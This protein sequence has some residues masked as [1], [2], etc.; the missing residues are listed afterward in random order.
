MINLELFTTK[1]K[2]DWIQ[3]DLKIAKGAG[4]V[5]IASVLALPDPEGT[6]EL[7][8]E[9]ERTGCVDMLE[10]NVSCPMPASTVGMHI[11]NN[12]EK[13]RAQVATVRRITKL[14]LLVKM[15]P[16][17]S[18]IG[19]VARACE[20]AGADGLC[21]ANSV[22]AFPGVDVETGRPVLAALGGYT[23]P[24]VKPI[25]ERFLIEAQQA[26]KLPISAVGG[27]TRW[28]DIVEYIMLGA[29]TVQVA[30]AVMW[31]GWEVIS[32][33]LRGLEAYMERH[34]YGGLDEI[35][36]IALQH[37]KTV[38]ELA[39][40]PRATPTVDADVCTG[41]GE[42]VQSCFYDALILEDVLRVDRERCDGCGLCLLICPT[43]ALG[44]EPS[45]A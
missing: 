2:K 23:G 21:I 5:V 18:D 13:T 29:T 45:S 15:T 19:S 4:G 39:Q 17:V 40:S 41:C 12:P 24:A 27:V 1:S 34:A 6:A 9:V 37:L 32:K 22:R 35:R 16:N 10:L 30:T 11:G 26:C 8:T 3:K 31:G 43:H 38:E 14:P 7:A 44:W 28:Q 25:T 20:E 42:C 36:G 33:Y